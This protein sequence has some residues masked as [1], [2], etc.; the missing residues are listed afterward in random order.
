M[1]GILALYSAIIQTSPFESPPGPLPTSDALARIPPH[2]RP[3]AGWRWLIRI[4]RPPLVGLEPT[5]HLLDLFLSI[6][7]VTLSETFGVQIT[8]LCR[9]LL[10]DGII[11]DKAGF[12]TKSRPS[13]VKLQLALESWHRQ[14]RVVGLVGQQMED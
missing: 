6:T 1:A 11:P 3:A 12:A 7:G 8:K 13:L 4:L 14:G 5:P 10:D 2:F 9:S